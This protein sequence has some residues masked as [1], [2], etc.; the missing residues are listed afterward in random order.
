[1]KIDFTTR[2]TYIAWRKEWVKQYLEVSQQIRD[3]RADFRGKQPALSR[4]GAYDWQ[5]LTRHEW[6]DAHKEVS[7]AHGILLS[8]REKANE[9]LTIRAL[10]K[11]EANKQWLAERNKT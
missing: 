9:L 10:S 4:L 8:L 1:M 6:N 5:S 3:A 2:E 7:K 11:V